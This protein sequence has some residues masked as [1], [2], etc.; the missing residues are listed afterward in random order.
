MVFSPRL[1]L[2]WQDTSKNKPGRWASAA[3]AV[4]CLPG[5]ANFAGEITVLFGAWGPLRVATVLTAWGALLIGA[6]YMLRA[7]RNI[8]HGPLPASFASVVDANIWR[9]TPFVMLIA[10][11]LV[12]GFFPRLLMDKIAPGTTRADQIY[13]PPGLANSQLATRP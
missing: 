5:F 3:W 10:S 12:F 8:L 2:R 9:K 4:C 13:R 6:I 11:L 7:V 1:A